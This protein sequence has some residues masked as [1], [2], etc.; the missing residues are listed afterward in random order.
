MNVTFPASNVLNWEPLL[1]YIAN[2]LP[3]HMLAW[4]IGYWLAPNYGT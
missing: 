1:S 4:V 3:L 2:A